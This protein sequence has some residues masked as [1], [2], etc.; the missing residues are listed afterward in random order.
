MKKAAFVA[1]LVIAAVFGVSRPSS[2]AVTASSLSVV[3]PNP[4]T[5]KCPVNVG[6]T[7]SISGSPGTVF[8]YSFNRFVNSVQQVVNGATVT[9]P[10]GGTIAVNDSVPISAST[11]G[12][13]FDQ[14]WVHNI[15]GGQPDVYSNLAKFT[16]NCQSGNGSIS[17]VM[18]PILGIWPPTPTGLTNTTDVDTCATHVNKLFCQAAI[19]AG[20]MALIWNWSGNASYPQLDGYK[21]YQW[22]GGSPPALLNTSSAGD[23]PKGAFLNAPSDG[24]NGKCYI[25]TAY[26]GSSESPRSNVFCVGGGAT[27]KTATLTVELARGFGQNRYGRTGVFGSTTDKGDPCSNLCIGF[28]HYT[29]ISDLGDMWGSF[30][31]RSA[32]RF[33]INGLSPSAIIK[34]VLHLHRAPNIGVGPG[35]GDA[36]NCVTE[37]ALGVNQWWS[38]TGPIAGDFANAIAVGGPGPDVNVDVT[39]LA[40]HWVGADNNGIVLRGSNETLTTFDNNHCNNWFDSHNATLDLVYN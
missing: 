17:Q 18:A 38:S 33:D 10:G 27:A 4:L 29:T 23:G 1:F 16:V 20:Q 25:V 6:F 37:A 12:T 2:A 39:P 5:A 32:V 28:S 14:V 22:K 7:G 31:Y 24:F 3:G 21:V 26:V 35:A 36:A 9:M 15:S 30:V 13:T 11:S 8:T 19:G 34:A 40:K